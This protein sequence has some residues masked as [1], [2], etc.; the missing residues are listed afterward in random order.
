[1]QAVSFAMLKAEAQRQQQ[2]AAETRSTENSRAKL[3]RQLEADRASLAELQAQQ[4]KEASRLEVRNHM[5]CKCRG[6]MIIKGIETGHLSWLAALHEAFLAAVVA[7]QL[8]GFEKVCYCWQQLIAQ[9][10]WLPAHHATL[11]QSD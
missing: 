7:D 9:S 8:C 1:M 4:R 6:L 2:A 3:C 11:T 10:S 5:L